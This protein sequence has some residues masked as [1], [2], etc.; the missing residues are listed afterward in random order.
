MNSIFSLE[1]RTENVPGNPELKGYPKALKKQQR[2]TKVDENIFTTTLTTQQLNPEKGCLVKFSNDQHSKMTPNI[3]GEEILFPLFPAN[4]LVERILP[5]RTV[6][7][8][9]TSL[10]A[11]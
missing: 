6:D 10:A 3:F 4:Y 1:A 11:H 2:K 7:A 8:L 5:N 9:K